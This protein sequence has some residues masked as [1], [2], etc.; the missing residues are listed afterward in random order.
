MSFVLIHKVRGK[1]NLSQSV[2]EKIQFEKNPRRTSVLMNKIRIKTKI[3]SIN[4][5]WFDRIKNNSL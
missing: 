1:A 3:W 2:I 4:E 5:L